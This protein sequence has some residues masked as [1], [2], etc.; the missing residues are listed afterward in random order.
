MPQI[1]PNLHRIQEVNGTIDACQEAICRLMP[2]MDRSGRKRMLPFLL[3]SDG[4]K[5]LNR[6]AAVWEQQYLGRANPLQQNPVDLAAQLETWYA[7]YKQLWARTS[8]GE[9][10]VPHRS[11]HLL[12]GRSAPELVVT[13]LSPKAST[14][15]GALL[16]PGRRQDAAALVQLYKGGTRSPA[17]YT[18]TRL[19]IHEI[20]LANHGK[21]WH[22][23]STETELKEVYHVMDHVIKTILPPIIGVLELMGIFV[24]AW[25]ACGAFGITCK[26]YLPA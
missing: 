24:V 14:G 17:L 10:A 8:R 3:M 11:D 12:A 25:A 22:T 5:L 9:R 16:S 2:A 18:Y 7:S 6:L 19:K 20:F 26:K 15:P 21:L 1:Q 13:L 4:Q 23:G